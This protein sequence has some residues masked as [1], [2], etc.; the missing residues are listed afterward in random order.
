[1]LLPRRD[2]AF[3][4]LDT[5]VGN[6]YLINNLIGILRCSEQLELTSLPHGLFVA[7]EVLAESHVWHFFVV[8]LV[9]WDAPDVALEDWFVPS[10]KLQDAVLFLL[11]FLVHCLKTCFI[12]VVWSKRVV[13]QVE[14]LGG[15]V[16]GKLAKFWWW[17]LSF[18]MLCGWESSNIWQSP[19]KVYLTA[20]I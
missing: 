10:L 16:T 8:S 5:L 15:L 14:T 4:I 13:L 7:T 3:L 6:H 2:L 17:M 18:H 12:F 20:I 19:I 9:F 11:D 1:M